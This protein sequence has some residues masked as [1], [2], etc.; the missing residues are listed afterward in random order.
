VPMTRSASADLFIVSHHGQPISNAEC[1]CMDPCT[2]RHHE[3]RHRKGGQPTHEG[4]LPSPGL[5][6]S[7]R[8]QFFAA[9]RP[10]ITVPGMFIANLTDERSPRC[11][12]LRSRLP[13][14]GANAPPRPST[15][16]AR[17]ISRCRRKQDG[18]FTV[19]TRRN[20]FDALC[21]A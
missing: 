8:S 2:R 5:E 1:W 19:P 17:S 10:G 13:P 18:T 11:R 3:Q 16:A 21:G 6:D 7:G 20:G 9:Q 4:A 15:R 12:S 14:P